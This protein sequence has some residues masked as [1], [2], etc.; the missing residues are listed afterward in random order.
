M[1]GPGKGP[2]SSG[3]RMVPNIA[4]C[5]SQ[6]MAS[7]VFYAKKQML[8]KNWTTVLDRRALGPV[9]LEDVRRAHQCSSGTCQLCAHLA[10]S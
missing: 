4:S 3:L 5:Y 8:P 10:K 7:F 9:H 6:E 1:Q 2:S